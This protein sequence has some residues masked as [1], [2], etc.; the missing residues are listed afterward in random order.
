MEE[1]YYTVKEAIAYIRSYPSSQRISFDY[2]GDIEEPDFYMDIS[3]KQLRDI[4][5]RDVLGA[6]RGI[7]TGEHRK[8]AYENFKG[9]TV[10]ESLFVFKKY[11]D[12]PRI[13]SSWDSIYKKENPEMKRMQRQGIKTEE[14]RIR[15]GFNKKSGKPSYLMNED[16][17][18]SLKLEVERRQ[19]PI[20]IVDV[21]L[22]TVATIKT[23]IDE[24]DLQFD[25]DAII[26]RLLKKFQYNLRYESQG[27]HGLCIDQYHNLRVLLG[28]VRFQTNILRTVAPEVLS[29][30]FLD[31]LDKMMKFCDDL[32]HKPIEVDFDIEKQVKQFKESYSKE[33]DFTKL[34]SKLYNFEKYQLNKYKEKRF[35]HGRMKVVR[36]LNYQRYLVETYKKIEDPFWKKYFVDDLRSNFGIK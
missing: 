1:T 23:L 26:S 25:F 5:K 36:E 3:E 35:K 16:Y 13:L 19:L 2:F 10:V 17:L 9:E 8:E 32:L 20:K 4:L 24:N 30:E 28:E 21:P 27:Y 11:G 33:K 22:H 29:N 31:E 15:E 6:Y 14:E 7:P 18:F 34:A 12:N